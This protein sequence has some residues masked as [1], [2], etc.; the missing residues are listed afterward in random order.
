[1]P[2]N[3]GFK[4]VTEDSPLTI[5]GLMAFYDDENASN[6]EFNIGD[7]ISKWYDLSGNGLHA[8]QSVSA[9]QPSYTSKRLVFDG[10]Q[11]FL[12]CPLKYD[13]AGSEFT[14]Y[15]V[16]NSNGAPNDY[17]G[18]FSTRLASPNW[19][20]IGHQLPTDRFLL[21]STSGTLLE[22]SPTFADRAANDFIFTM[23]KENDPKTTIRVNNSSE[24]T[25]G[26]ATPY[27]TASQDT[28]IGQWFTVSQAWDGPIRTLLFFN[29]KVSADENTKVIRYLSD[30]KGIEV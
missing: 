16:Q 22:L 18:I 17:M 3:N 9:N 23:I 5:P 1:M 13:W 4:I 2:L 11:T 14:I 28:I 20:T 26:G 29:R 8:T 15:T 6:F 30:R 19:M 27:G 24:N 7:Q 25:S 10:A 21:E 12:E